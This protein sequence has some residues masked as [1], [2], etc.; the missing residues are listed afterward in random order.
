MAGRTLKKPSAKGKPRPRSGRNIAANVLERLKAHESAAV[1]KILL[2]R[3]PTLREEAEQI[4]TDL[5]SFPSVDEV[6][7]D[8]LAAVT[9]IG[10]DAVNARTGGRS[11]GYVDPTEAAWELFEEALEDVISDM[12]RRM[13]LSLADAAEAL[14]RGIVVGLRRAGEFGSDGALGWAPDFPA[15]KACDVVEELLRACPATERKNTRDR[16]LHALDGDVPQWSEMLQRATI[17]TFSRK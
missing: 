1:L 15:E 8:V 7:E 13:E 4:A 11:W 16:I 5:V 2:E 3:D 14:C 17:R 10:I 12:K 6:A 9:L